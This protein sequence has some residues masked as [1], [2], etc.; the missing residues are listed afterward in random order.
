MGFRSSFGMGNR[1]GSGVNFRNGK[2]KEHCVCYT[3][4]RNGGGISVWGSLVVFPQHHHRKLCTL[5]ATELPNCMVIPA[6]HHLPPV[7][8]RS[9]GIFYQLVGKMAINIPLIRSLAES[10]VGHGSNGI[11]SLGC[12]GGAVFGSHAMP[13]SG[14]RNSETIPNAL[15]HTT[16]YVLPR[17]CV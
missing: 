4:A 7:D 17:C 1:L 15:L 2:V 6:Q 14:F 11:V 12:N 3:L 13:Y 8:S 9:D 16:G 10:L 5:G